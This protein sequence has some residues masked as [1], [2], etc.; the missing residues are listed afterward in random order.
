MLLD[1]TWLLL[2]L[3][4]V[5]GLGWLASRFDLRQWR[6]ENQLSP[7]PYFKGLNHLLNGQHDQAI[8]AF[9]QAVQNDPD[10]T[11]LHFALGNLFRRRGDLDRAVR[12]HEHLLSRGDLSIADRE[13]AQMALAD[14]FLGAGLLDRAETALAPLK[15]T[16]FE[17]RAQ[18][19]LLTVFERSRDW[20]QADHA[21]Q[22]LEAHA[23]GSF[24][25]RRAH[26]LSERAATA[27]RENESLL[28]QAL[29]LEAIALAPDSARPRID[30]A[31]WYV[32]A[33]QPADAWLSLMAVLQL[34]PSAAPL[35][36]HPLAQLAVETQRIEETQRALESAQSTHRSL[37]VLEALVELDQKGAPTTTGTAISGHEGDTTLEQR[38]SSYL[39][40][41]SSIIAAT[42][43]L[44]RDARLQATVPLPLLHAIDHA[45][46]P[47]MRY[48][49]AACSFEARQHF[50]QCPGCQAWDSYPARRVEE[51]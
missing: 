22:W 35:V 34:A 11:E 40:K 20:Q 17:K 7:K 43:W 41:E 12:V 21:A 31:H 19:A 8:D 45:A 28:A 50:W 46:R 16:R 23:E 33:H 37:D 14:D 36:A 25:S 32:Q 26:Y 4:A 6:M 47:A 44:T 38:Y 5:F 2:L 29:L 51:L 39:E 3:P 9:V 13:R 15:G 18:L 27:L 48:R 24:A 1:L 30:L 49:C 42:R 10:T